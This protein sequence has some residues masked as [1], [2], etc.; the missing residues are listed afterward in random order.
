VDLPL[1]SGLGVY[2]EANCAANA[3]AH[4]YVIRGSTTTS[5]YSVDGETAFN[6][7]SGDA[8]FQTE[9]GSSS[10]VNFATGPGAI[11]FGEPASNATIGITDNGGSLNLDLI[12]G[13]DGKTM[14][15][16]VSLYEGQG[17][18]AVHGQVTPG[19]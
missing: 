16:T 1:F 8:Y 12:L 5:P 19:Q 11:D 6:G 2:V 15:M 9:N 3:A 4:L 10:P 13:R 17:S 18:C 7:T 14:T